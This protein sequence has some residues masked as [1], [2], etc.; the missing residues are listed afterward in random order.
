MRKG[1]LS[2][3]T[4]RSCLEANRREPPPDKRTR[5][6][7]ASSLPSNGVQELASVSLTMMSYKKY[8]MSE[9]SE[10]HYRRSTFKLFDESRRE[11]GQI[12]LSVSF[13]RVRRDFGDSFSATLGGQEF[14]GSF[15]TANKCNLLLNSR[16]FA[17]GRT[18]VSTRPKIFAFWSE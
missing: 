2:Q 13:I 4:S 16:R 15:L 17:Q 8:L 14:P 5:N 10:D 1:H 3:R 12:E 6:L 7:V 18:E 9:Q 11:V